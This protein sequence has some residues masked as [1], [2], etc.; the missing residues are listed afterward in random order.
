MKIT[1]IMNE[2]LP[3]KLRSIKNAPEKIYAMGN[4]EL[5]YKKSFAIVGTRRITEYGRKNCINFAE[6]L[7]LRNIPIVSG[8]AIGTDTIAHKTALENMNETIAVLGSGFKQIFP[9]E[10]ITLFEQIVENK[11]LIITEYEENCKANKNNF[12]KRNRIITALSEGILVIEAGYRSGTSITA[13]HAREQGKL[14]FAVPGRVDSKLGVGVNELIK[15]GAILTTKIEDILKYYPTFQEKIR[16]VKQ[17][18]YNK[19][20]EK[21]INILKEGEKSMQELINLSNMKISELFE[22]VTRME[23]ENIIFK[24][25][26]GKYVLVKL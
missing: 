19:E 14:V 17:K 8:M 20:F 24:N 5:L 7:S 23:L 21:I 2:E 3:E 6:E 18:N 13:K 26:L 16:R 9:R 12:P 15:K 22:V 4:I 25:Y 1:E 10:N 11:G